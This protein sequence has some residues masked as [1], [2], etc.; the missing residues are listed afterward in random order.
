[1]GAEAIDRAPEGGLIARDVELERI[2]HEL[3]AGDG[4]VL[5]G[6]AGIGKTTL[7][8]AGVEWARSAGYRVLVAAPAEAEGSF[9][10][11]VLGDLLGSVEE[12]RIAAL[13]PPQRRALE[14]VLL[15]A[16]SDQPTEVYAVGVAVLSVL[17]GLA[18]D[19]A[20]VVAIDD[21]QWV[22]AASAAALEFALRRV[23]SVRPLVSLRKG[24]ALPLQLSVARV[25]VGAMTPT[26]LH[27]LLVGRMGLA[28]SPT[29]LR[30]LHEVSGGNPFYALELARAS[31]SGEEL[32]VPESLQELVTGRLGTLP[33]PTRRSLGELALAGTVEP[34]PELQAAVEAG[35]VET[36]DGML[37]FSH[38]LLAEAAASVLEPAERR[39]LHH[40]IAAR[41]PE[42]DRR[43]R[44]LA[45]A[46]E[47]PDD[48]VALEL[49]AAAEDAARHG[50]IAVAA[51]LWELAAG[52][53]KPEST[54]LVVERLVE[55]G[56]AHSRAGSSVGLALL[57][58][59]LDRLLPG[60]LRQRGR[61]DMTLWLGR[62]DAG[63]AP[64]LL[65]RVLAET[66]DPW[67]RLEVSQIL[68]GFFEGLGDSL[69]G[70][71]I[72]QAYLG[73]AELGDDATLVDALWF[74][75]YWEIGC[76]RS[77]WPLIVRARALPPSTR[78][79]GWPVQP[80]PKEVLARAL[81]REG[82]IDE[83]RTQLEEWAEEEGEGTS[84]STHQGL[85][86][87]LATVELAAGR[88]D[89]AASHADR[90]LVEG[91]QAGR[92]TMICEGLLHDATVA[93]MLGKA[94]R[95]R[96]Q[97]T[98]A[99]A[100]G[101]QTGWIDS[102]NNALITLGL[103]ELS[104][105][106]HREAAVLYRRVPVGGWRRWRYW[107]GGRATLDAVEALSAVGE[108]DPAR[109]LVATLPA[110]ARELG[111]ARA[112][113]AA[114]EGDLDHAIELVRSAPP[115]P[116]PFRHGREL[117]LLGRLQRQRRHRTEAR[118]TLEAART[119]FEQLGAVPWVFRAE[120]E[121]A[122][123]GGR[124]SAGATLT[125]S[126]RRVAAL[127]ADGLSNKEVAARLVVTVRTVEAHLSKTYAK[128]GIRSRGELAARWPNL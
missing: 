125:E 77:P 33:A 93:L 104:L 75:A 7:W 81:L 113:L 126:E 54:T 4:V 66:E 116:S 32:V 53:T 59:N 9:S 61:L 111:A 68:A 96:S 35:V 16:E 73:E 120:D 87:L 89:A 99:L 19:G 71:K 127:V 2:E 5:V 18:G 85:L 51:E 47:A 124:S 79:G 86:R 98:R 36:R 11:A 78:R 42:S 38:P 44:H 12:E 49:A 107:D 1:V 41:T 108:L 48:A 100:L 50:A 13:R 82:R 27:H 46:A 28:W 109:E 52:L 3:G 106:D 92:P 122:R 57:E 118:E 26:G 110:D 88:F 56:V 14:S 84:I 90:L 69:G 115:A 8:R 105:G 23:E 112:C 62:T 39:A 103:L 80:Q 29:A 114:A 97:A 31:R 30:H 10:Y 6:E 40:E 117:L 45:L 37:R 34:G 15:I 65:E 43:A 60:S 91:E 67:F 101:Q 55:A 22:D 94:E 25:E 20:V 17:E 24:H 74:A 119:E 95:A 21:V 121:L 102:A 70:A 72:A 83:A 76:D 128:L 58:A 123:L 63:A 64:R